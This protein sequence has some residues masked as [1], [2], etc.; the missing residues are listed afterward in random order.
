MSEGGIGRFLDHVFSHGATGLGGNGLGFE[1]GADRGIVG[2]IAIAPR[3]GAVI[4]KQVERPQHE[5]G[6][7][8]RE[9]GS[10]PLAHEGENRLELVREGLH[11][12]EAERTRATLD[13]VEPN[14][15]CC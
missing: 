11:R 5:I 4:G 12:G 6:R 3:G 13:R 2:D 10:T 14:G 1:I 8:C 15:R 7:D 9:S